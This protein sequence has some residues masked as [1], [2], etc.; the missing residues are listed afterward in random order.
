[1]GSSQAV[2]SL[3]PS[4]SSI[5]KWHIMLLA[6]APCQCSSP[7]G[8]QTVSPGR[9]RMTVPS[10]VAIRPMPSVHGRDQRLLRSATGVTGHELP[11]DYGRLTTM[12]SCEDDTH[13]SADSGRPLSSNA[14][15]RPSARRRK[16]G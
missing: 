1:M 9:I 11:A 15:D 6:V 16:T 7:G 8:V 12:P 4:P 13:R 3:V 14:F 2:P 5:A 10:R